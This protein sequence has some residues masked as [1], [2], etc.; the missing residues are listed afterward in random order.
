MALHTQFGSIASDD[1]VAVSGGARVTARS[2]GSSDQT[3]LLL[4]QITN[5]IKDL[6]SNKNQN[7]PTQL[8]LM[9]M[10][11]GGGL[12]GGGGGGGGGGPAFAPPMP[13]PMPAAPAPTLH[14]ST[15]VSH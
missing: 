15:R 1:L 12:G 9:M 14:I 10:L 6:S 13:P 5:S 3:T 4:T 8:L 7:D 2:T 11:L